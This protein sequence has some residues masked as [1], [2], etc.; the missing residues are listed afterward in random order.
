MDSVRRSVHSLLLQ[1]CLCERGL[2]E[3]GQ[4]L[5]AIVEVNWLEPSCLFNLYHSGLCCWRPEFD[6]I[7]DG[8]ERDKLVDIN[9]LV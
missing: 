4:V 1:H 5:E 9:N 3:C 2:E 8:E 7:S 6:L